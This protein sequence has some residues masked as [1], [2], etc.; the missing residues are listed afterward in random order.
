MNILEYFNDDDIALENLEQLDQSI[1][2]I[3]HEQKDT[4]AF[5]KALSLECITLLSSTQSQIQDLKSQSVL[6]N[7]FLSLFGKNASLRDTILQ[8]S[9]KTQQLT[10][11]LF[12]TIIK[13]CSQN[14]AFLLYINQEMN[15]IYRELKN[16]SLENQSQIIKILDAF[17]AFYN[18]KTANEAA[19]KEEFQKTKDFIYSFCLSC[20]HPLKKD[21]YLCPQCGKLY[22]DK[23][24][25]LTDEARSKLSL[26]ADCITSVDN[27]AEITW[28]DQ[29]CAI[30][31]DIAQL[32]KILQTGY[33][34]GIEDNLLKDLNEIRRL[35]LPKEF[36]IALVGSIKA[37][38][39]TLINAL[40]NL[41]LASVDVN[42][43]TTALTKFRY[44]ENG[45][46]IRIHF[47]SEK[48][49]DQLKQ[50]IL[51]SKSTKLKEFICSPKAAELSKN[52]IGEPDQFIAVSDTDLTVLK[53]LIYKWTSTRSSKSLC[54]SELEVGIDKNY[55]PLPQEVVLVDTPGLQD[56]VA[57]R[58]DIT[59][60]YLSH[61][62]A[63]FI[64]VRM[65]S[66]STDELQ[67]IGT[68]M[69]CTNEKQ[70]KHTYIIATQIDRYSSRK[71]MTLLEKWCEDFRDFKW[72]ASPESARAKI[73]TT[74][75]Y[76][77]FYLKRFVEVTD[78][79]LGDESILPED[80]LNALESYAKVILGTGRFKR[81]DY[82]QLR[83]NKSD[84]DILYDTFGINHISILL[85]QRFLPD[86]RKAQ[87]E[88]LIEK[89]QLCKTTL[90]TI[91]SE[92]IRQNNILLNDH[93]Q[94][95]EALKQA[96]SSEEKTFHM[97]QEK[98]HELQA[99]AD[100]LKASLYQLI[101]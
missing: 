101:Q 27:K 32:Q 43:E 47:Y 99:A 76:L 60:N 91:V 82:F 38:K 51:E 36:Q 31:R 46:Y 95:V 13:T 56:P 29:A 86:F 84:A 7:V 64:T 20:G 70:K 68:V 92:N 61:S 33:L 16:D 1:T 96:F 24:P 23:N 10:Q 25:K 87:L 37:G 62:N 22:F 14:Q 67:T 54:V 52:Y 26:L 94:T 78:E 73:K 40:L 34:T 35:C 2:Q 21:Q 97:E 88:I 41:E 5:I 4:E 8:N 12:D 42:P 85:S 63:V 81:Y 17:T 15:S 66:L 6:K 80:A 48:E 83:Q 55:F 75:A 79:Q 69:A 30:D 18:E 58:S 93:L 50:S 28:N 49:W 45:F 11:Y 59:K 77:H 72:Y 98:Y 90:E 9:I 19:Q 65:D 100:N 39:S 74:S 71:Q 57:Y 53:E 3:V 44:S 89:Y